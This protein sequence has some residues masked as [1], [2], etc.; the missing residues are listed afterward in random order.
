MKMWSLSKCF[1]LDFISAKS[2]ACVP[3]IITWQRTVLSSSA[4]AAS[5]VLSISGKHSINPL[6]IA[7]PSSPIFDNVK[8]LPGISSLIVRIRQINCKNAAINAECP[9]FWVFQQY[10]QVL[11]YRQDIVVAHCK[12]FKVFYKMR[13][14]IILTLQ[15]QR[16]PVN[17]FLTGDNIH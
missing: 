15:K 4:T 13:L 12:F 9:W 5:S 1:P 10:W 8:V 6:Q 3:R 17:F 14:I 11:H 2:F 7:L 16:G